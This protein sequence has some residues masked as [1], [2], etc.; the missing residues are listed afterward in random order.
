MVTQERGEA[1]ATKRSDVREALHSW[2]RACQ[3]FDEVK[4][5]TGQT[6]ADRQG[7]LLEAEKRI[8]KAAD[9]YTEALYAFKARFATQG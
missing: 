9:A 1:T 2:L 5:G 3:E 8:D 4:R 6:D 7:L